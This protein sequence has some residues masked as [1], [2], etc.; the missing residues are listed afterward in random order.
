MTTPALSPMLTRDVLHFLG[1]EN[2]APTLESLDSLLHAYTRRVPWES[3]F[4]IAKRVRTS[5]TMDCA[6]WP[7]EFWR[8]AMERGGGGTCFESNYAFFSL[9]R[10]LGFEGYL[11]IN[12]MGETVGCHTAIIL[13]INGEKWLA[14][15]G[16]PFYVALPVRDGEI[17]GRDSEFVS[18]T[19]TPDGANRYHIQRQPHPSPN[20]FTLIDRPVDDASYRIATTRDYLPGGYFLD[21]VV[22]N[23]IV[24][25]RQWRFNSADLPL[26]LEEFVDGQKIDHFIE[27]DP[28]RVIGE[29]FGMDV[30][31]IRTAL[32]VTVG[33]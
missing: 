19:L 1:I 10:A 22:V 31:T 3:A 24:N 20:A 9:L 30:D 25:E 26:R 29:H 18:Y 7:E 32:G 23:K 27:G 15:V 4:R 5:E 17:S 14:D 12:N 28:A 6:R 13:H 8:D 21:R 11:T 2:P 33:A 16:M